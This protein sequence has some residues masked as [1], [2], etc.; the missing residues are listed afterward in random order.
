MTA[1]MEITSAAAPGRLHACPVVSMFGEGVEAVARPGNMSALTSKNDRN[2]VDND[3]KPSETDRKTSKNHQK[4]IENGPKSIKKRI[5]GSSW[6][7][8]DRRVLP[9]FSRT[10]S[11]CDTECHAMT[12]RESGAFFMPP[13]KPTMQK[14]KRGMIRVSAMHGSIAPFQPSW[15]CGKWHRGPHAVGTQPAR[16]NLGHC[17][18]LR[19]RRRASGGMA[20]AG[21]LKSPGGN[22]VRVRVPPCPI[23]NVSG[24]ATGSSQ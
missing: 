1:R 2:G 11:H 22:L 16:T 8:S 13:T 15:Q 23:E 10:M 19:D 5:V 18:S 6:P 17:K 21:D 7:T 14:T 9:L 24:H 3:Q 12:P 20:D 4:T